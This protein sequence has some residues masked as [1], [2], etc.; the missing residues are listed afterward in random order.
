MGNGCTDDIVDGNAILPF[1]VGK[2]LLSKDL[3]ARVE[4]ACGGQFWN[5]TDGRALNVTATRVGIRGFGSGKV[6]RVVGLR[7]GRRNASRCDVRF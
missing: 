1:A 3:Y 6:Y 4:D 2:A 5:V 7:L